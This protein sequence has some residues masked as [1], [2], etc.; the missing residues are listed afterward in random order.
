MAECRAWVQEYLRRDNDGA[1]V[2]ASPGA[3]S[4]DGADADAAT[5]ID[6]T[7]VSESPLGG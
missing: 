4:A 5:V 2:P 7:T 6:V 1:A 3:G